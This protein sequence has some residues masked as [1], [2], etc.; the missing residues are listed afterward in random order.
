MKLDENIS[1]EVSNHT[2]E[3]ST[4]YIIIVQIRKVYAQVLIF[5]VQDGSRVY[6]QSVCFTPEEIYLW[7]QLCKASSYACFKITNMIL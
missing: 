6:P 7:K 4:T 2:L 3:Y 5:F 1:R